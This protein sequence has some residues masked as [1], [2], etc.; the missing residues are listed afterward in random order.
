M[1]LQVNGV[2]PYVYL[3]VYFVLFAMAVE[4]DGFTLDC[5]SVALRKYNPSR[6]F[7]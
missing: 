5:S 3:F 7:F 1:R 2:N 6:L 4:L